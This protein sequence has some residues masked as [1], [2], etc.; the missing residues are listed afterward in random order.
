MTTYSMSSTRGI[1][2][3]AYTDEDIDFGFAT[4]LL[5]EVGDPYQQWFYDEIARRGWS[6]ERGVALDAYPWCADVLIRKLEEGR[7][8]VDTSY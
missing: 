6:I 2:R 7:G 8:Y 3:Y 4:N 5:S 1:V